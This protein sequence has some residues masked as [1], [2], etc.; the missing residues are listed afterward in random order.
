MQ[1]VPD[2]KTS[3]VKTK[4]DQSRRA[5]VSYGARATFKQRVNVP[6][7]AD[8]KAW[9]RNPVAKGNPLGGSVCRADAPGG[10]GGAD[11]AVPGNR[12]PVFQ[13]A[14]ARLDDFWG[15]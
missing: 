3:P 8:A 10:P 11:V 6:R 15:G 13:R 1:P 7:A 9:P 12:C 2:T 5:S 14:G 4:Q